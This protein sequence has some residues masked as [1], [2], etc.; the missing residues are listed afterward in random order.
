MKLRNVKN[1]TLFNS[2]VTKVKPIF[3][4]LIPWGVS[5]KRKYKTY[6]G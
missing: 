4:T 1:K 6:N 5:K 3:Y 2:T